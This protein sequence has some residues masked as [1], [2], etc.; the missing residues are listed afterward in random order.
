MCSIR[1]MSMLPK[2][3]GHTLAQAHFLCSSSAGT[4]HGPH[5]QGDALSGKGTLMLPFPDSSSAPWEMLGTQ[6]PRLMGLKWS[7]V[8]LA[9]LLG[10]E[11]PFVEIGDPC[12]HGSRVG[13]N[14]DMNHLTLML[15]LA[16]PSSTRS[17]GDGAS[18][19]IFSRP[20]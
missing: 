7:R 16:S 3:H 5:Y 13:L 1:H 15:C 20:G 11:V 8:Q 14:G 12:M 18:K 2:R 6:E 10:R 17:L 9:F 19:T 4:L